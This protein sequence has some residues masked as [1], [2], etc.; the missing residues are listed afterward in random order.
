LFLPLFQAPNVVEL[1]R[2]R[3]RNRVLIIGGIAGVLLAI[4]GLVVLLYLTTYSPTPDIETILGHSLPPEAKVAGT[5][6]WRYH[7][8]SRDGL[9][10]AA[11][12]IGQ[13]EFHDLAHAMGL[14]RIDARQVAVFDR[15]PG[16][17]DWWTLAN[18]PNSP[19][20]AKEHRTAK[21]WEQ[22][23]LKY[24]DGRMYVHRSFYGSL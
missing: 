3:K 10:K 7:P 19:V 2:P 23:Y 21:G 17:F 24:E 1:V 5:Y 18:K 15:M 14:E 11:V 22:I 8:W 16:R 9:N 4:I 12:D 6:E 20:Y 13:S